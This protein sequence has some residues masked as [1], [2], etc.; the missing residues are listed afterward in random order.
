MK[1]S[2]AAILRTQYKGPHDLIQ[3]S[4]GKVLFLRRWDAKEESNVSVLI[5]HGITGHSGPYGQM[6]ADE[7]CEAG[8]NVFGIDL[9]GHGLSDG[10]R[11]DYP[12]KDRFVKDLGETVALAKSRSKK[13]VVLGHSLG[14]LAAVAAAKENPERVDGLV[15]VGAA[16]RIRTGV[17][18]RPSPG[19]M[20]KTLL[21]VAIFRGNPVIEYRRE[22]QVGID[23]PLFNFRYSARFYSVLYGVGALKVLGMIRSGVIDS[24]N[25]TFDAKLGVP[26]IVAVGYED[27][28]F[29]ADAARDFC[30]GI[31]CD[32]K[33]FHLIPEASHAVWP[34]GAFAPLLDWLGRK[35]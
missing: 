3:A 29:T 11:G 28:L 12:S 20:A 18:P 33:E 25:L 8:Y 32:D 15:L 21:G 27:E 24:P 22:G 23:D 26:L 14:A 2:D 30:E 6:V 4:D 34:E 1:V 5:F 13:L 35:F 17:Y 10:R 16:T 19:A 9:R 7:L 31:D